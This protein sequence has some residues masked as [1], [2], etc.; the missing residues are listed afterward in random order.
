MSET[1]LLIDGYSLAF[2]A[3]YGV[4]TG[5]FMTSTGQHT[6]AVFGFIS[7]LL[8]TIRKYQPTHLAVAWD[9]SRAC[10]R[11][12]EYPAYKGTRSD[13]PPEFNGQADLIRQVLDAAN[14][15]HLDKP[16]YEA[17]D[18]IATLATRGSASGATVLICTGDRDLFQIVNEN[19]NVLWPGRG[20]TG[21]TRLDPA[22]VE[23]KY[24]VSPQRYPELAALVGETSDNLPGVPGV[25]PKTAAKWLNEFDGLDNLLLRAAELP[26]KAGQSLRDNVDNVLRN[27]K[28]NALVTTLDLPVTLADLA[29]RPADSSAIHQIFDA[30]QFRQL[31]AEMLSVLSTGDE[32]STAPE[33][34]PQPELVV[35]RVGE[36]ESVSKWLDDHSA[37]TVGL[38]FVGRWGRGRGDI[39]AVTIANVEGAALWLDPTRLG[40]ADELALTRWLADSSKSKIAHAFKGPMEA[41]WQRGWQPDGVVCDTE[42]AAYLLRPDS[43]SYPLDSLAQQYLNRPLSVAQTGSSEAQ[44]ALPTEDDLE[45]ASLEAAQRART[46][47][48]LG[49]VLCERLGELGQRSLL[50]DVEMPLQ[51]VLADMEAVGIA[52]DVPVLDSLSSELEKRVDKAE[53]AAFA[54]IGKQVNLGSPKQLQVLLFDELDMP[55][56]KKIRTGYTTDADALA[57]LY[58]KTEHPFLAHLLEH[59]DAIKL[60]QMVD[61][62]LRAVA[63]DNRIHTTFQQSVAATGRLSSSDPNLQNIP[64][65]TAEGARVREAFVAG[66]GY[67]GL[68]SVDYSQIEMRVMADASGDEALIEAFRSGVDFHTVTASHVFRV[69]TADVTPSM[70]ASVKGMNY[71]LAYGLSAFGLSNRLGVSVS[72]AKSLMSDYFATFGKVKLYLDEVVAEAKRVGYTETKLGRRRYL[73]DLNSPNH[74]LREM[75]ERAALNAPIQGTAADIIK[76]AMIRLAHELDAHKLHSRVLLQVHDELILEVAPGEREEL[77]QLVSHV[78]RH[79][80]DLRV[81]LDVSVGFGHSWAAAAH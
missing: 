49:Q 67:E 57:E 55:K 6:N 69:P 48:E 27:R 24:G 26:G 18:I 11:T 74:Q 20:V 66:T 14:I 62:L 45:S 80:L 15:V 30:L 46:V 75:A 73:P 65:R 23:D 9:V 58:S 4:P 25:G 60:R 22:G 51:R 42:L 28:L 44:S 81:P 13:A 36:S 5:G 8:P 71:G 7:M 3:F 78:M 79:A 2:R 54:V 34:T 77:E 29:R 43:R 56:T 12:D 41:A 61:G 63:D 32:P 16:G 39:E 70:R 35:T 33:P 1:L 64:I 38:D 76:V 53:Q 68:L 19:V 21:P 50:D 47:A 31:R 72:E 40:S 59:R 10:F 37:G 17:D 52:I